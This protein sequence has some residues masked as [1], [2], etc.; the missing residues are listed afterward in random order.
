MKTKKRSARPSQKDLATKLQLLLNG[1]PLDEVMEACL[2]VGTYAAAMLD[3]GED[4][5]VAG[6]RACY[7]EVRK[8]KAASGI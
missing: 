4:K 7:R 8:R 2:G 1:R 5:L 6:T 3:Y